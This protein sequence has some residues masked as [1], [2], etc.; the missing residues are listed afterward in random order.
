MF[1]SGLSGATGVTFDGVAGTDFVIID[2]TS[3]LVTAPAHALGVVDVEVTVGLG[4]LSGGFEYRADTATHAI[5]GR[6]DAFNAGTWAAV[7]AGWDPDVFDGDSTSEAVPGHTGPDTFLEIE[8]GPLDDAVIPGD[9]MLEE[10]H[11]TFDWAVELTPGNTFQVVMSLGR[12][13]ETVTGDSSGD[14]VSGITVPGVTWDDY[15]AAHVQVFGFRFGSDT[16]AQPGGSA[17]IVVSNFQIHVTYSGGTVVP[18]VTRV[19][20]TRG[21]TSGGRPVRIIGSGFTGTPGVVTFG[22]AAATDV[23]VMSDT[24]IT[25]RTPAH[26]AGLVDVDVDGGTLEDAYLYTDALFGDLTIRYE[27]GILIQDTLNDAP[28][29][30][31]MRCERVGSPESPALGASVLIEDP[32]SGAVL[33][34]GTALVVTDGIDG[35]PSNP[36]Y[37]DLTAGDLAWRFNAVRPFKTYTEQPADVVALDLIDLFAPQFTGVIEAGLPNISLRC[38]RSQTMS[39]VFS[40]IAGLIQGSWYPDDSFGIHLFLTNPADPPDPITDAT[41]L[42]DPPPTVTRDL[43]QVRNRVFV[44]GAGAG[45]AYL[46]PAAQP[47]ISN[48]DVL[49]TTGGSIPNADYEYS[50]TALTADGETIPLSFGYGGILDLLPSA[51]N[52][53]A[54][55]DL[56]LTVLADPRVIGR[57]LYRNR[58]TEDITVPVTTGCVTRQYLITTLGN[59]AGIGE[60]TFFDGKADAELIV[61][62]PNIDSSATIFVTVEDAAAQAYLAALLNVDGGDDDGVRDGYVV[63]QSLTTMEMATARANAELA[64]WSYP[65]ET[66]VLAARD[67]KLVSGQ[68]V[69]IT[70]SNPAASGTFKIQHVRIDQV[71]AD[72]AGVLF[73]RRTITASSV[74]FT[75]D[76]LLRGVVLADGTGFR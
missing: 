66:V 9:A 24:L 40:V 61:L 6:A 2:S 38:D 26:A 22:G 18:S 16:G 10:L 74:R 71:Q 7:A 42:Y 55:S 41:P 27:Q 39:E 48:M 57:K 14:L 15:L 30:A 3:L 8:G 69:S 11:C 52:A 17:R 44:K 60:D 54:L 59:T 68:M 67:E 33:F 73:A 13:F 51:N 49:P 5:T 34:G 1:G 4:T 65:I 23:L 72:A 37:R 21:P 62:A 20:P 36:G 25:A 45:D 53:F 29:S 19:I 12:T 70:L 76:D 50:M 75:L 47:P 64:L 28:N 58:S 35:R 31:V 56:D 63:D 32:A 43:T 46:S